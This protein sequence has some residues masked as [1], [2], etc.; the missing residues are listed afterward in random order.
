MMIGKSERRSSRLIVLIYYHAG[1]LQ[2]HRRETTWKLGVVRVRK[3]NGEQA[4][5]VPSADGHAAE[6]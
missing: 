3:V 4:K 5:Y 6:E 1:R 2:G